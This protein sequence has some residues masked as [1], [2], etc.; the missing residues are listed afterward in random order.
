[1]YIFSCFYNFLLF[2][3]PPI[4][5]TSSKLDPPEPLWHNNHINIHYF[6][7]VKFTRL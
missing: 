1:M 5:P 3:K 4:Y 2:I 7:S 6:Y